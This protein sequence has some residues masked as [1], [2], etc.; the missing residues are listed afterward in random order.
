MEG[1]ILGVNTMYMLFCFL[2]LFPIGCIG[3]IWWQHFHHWT[4]GVSV[5]H[6]V[7]QIDLHLCNGICIQK[8]IYRVWRARW[9]MEHL[10][11]YKK[12]DQ[13]QVWYVGVE[14]KKNKLHMW[15][16]SNLHQTYKIWKPTISAY[17]VLKFFKCMQLAHQHTYLLSP[18][19]FT[20]DMDHIRLLFESL[21]H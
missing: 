6:I 18:I 15:I 8:A 14:K 11:V 16:L 1:L 12:T 17:I 13:W 2:K 3:L 19:H 7:V 20:C 9:L 4:R 5:V 10:Q 21:C